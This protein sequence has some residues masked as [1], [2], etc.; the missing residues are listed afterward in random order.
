MKT[1]D[2]NL[3]ELCAEGI[4]Q[5]RR[6]REKRKRLMDILVIIILS[7]GCVCAIIITTV[8]MMDF[9]IEMNYLT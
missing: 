2:E 5:V 8:V 3:C 7:I 4:M 6:S 1:I 9:L